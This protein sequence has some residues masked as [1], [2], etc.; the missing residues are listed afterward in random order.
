MSARTPLV[1]GEADL[2]IE[3]I[4]TNKDKTWLTDYL[5]ESTAQTFVDTVQGV[6]FHT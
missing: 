4:I 3:A 6:R 5:R 1:P 2:W